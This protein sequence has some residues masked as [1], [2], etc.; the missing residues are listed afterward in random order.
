MGFVAIRIVSL[1]WV[2]NTVVIIRHRQIIT[3]AAPIRR[4]VF[5]D[6]ALRFCIR[7]STI[8]RMK[9]TTSA[10]IAIRRLPAMVIAALFVVIP[11]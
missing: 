3:A 2:R 5:F 4:F 9:S 7:F 6:P 11:L 10:S 1:P 8:P